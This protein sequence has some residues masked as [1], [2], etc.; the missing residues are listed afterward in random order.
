MEKN[1]ESK[2]IDRDKSETKRKFN[3]HYLFFIVLAAIVIYAAVRLVVWNIGTKDT[4]EITQE[5]SEFDIESMDYILPL[6]P[7]YLEG[8]EDDGITTVVCFGNAPFADDRNEKNN[9]AVLIEKELGEIAAH[10]NFNPA[11]CI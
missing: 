3:I 2:Q 11:I 8:R 7:K 6:N 9:L 5:D 1:W 4:T 10:Y